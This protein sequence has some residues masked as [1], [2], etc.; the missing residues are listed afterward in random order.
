MLTLALISG[1]GL[2]EVLVWLVCVGLV[3]WLLWWLVDYV[4]L[5]EPFGK[6]ARVVLAVAGVVVLI[7]VL[8]SIAGHPMVR[9]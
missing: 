8:M 3:F 2:V 4:K 9:W 1:Q 6:V 7:N 5:P